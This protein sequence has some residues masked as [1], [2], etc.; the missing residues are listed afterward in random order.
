MN[1]RDSSPVENSLVDLTK[2]SST[3]RNAFE[4]LGQPIAAGALVQLRD[5]CKR[6]TPQYNTKYD[7][8]KPLN[9]KNSIEY[10]PYA[11]GEPLFDDRP[12][13]TT[14]LPRGYSLAPAPKKARSSWL[15]QVGY[16]LVKQQWSTT[17]NMW[18]CKHCKYHSF[19]LYHKLTSI[20]TKSS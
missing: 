11:N 7:P 3:S 4:V 16:A 17:Q 13:N 1:P 20:F 12:L 15:S 18:C 14:H 19:L 9:T 2:T 6:P 5:K 8:Y 10:S